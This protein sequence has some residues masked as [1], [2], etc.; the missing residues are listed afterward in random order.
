MLTDIL[1]LLSKPEDG[2]DKL[3]L[4]RYHIE[5]IGGVREEI[6]AVIRIKEMILRHFASDKGNSK[7]TCTCIITYMYTHTCMF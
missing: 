7:H 2:S 3:S 5:T 1:V 4:K 6:S